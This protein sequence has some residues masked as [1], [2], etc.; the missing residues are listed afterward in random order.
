[1]S[2][3]DLYIDR[4]KTQC[5]VGGAISRAGPQVSKGKENWLRAEQRIR[6]QI[7]LPSLLSA[8]DCEC[9]E[10]ISFTPELPLSDGV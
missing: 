5:T 8:L 3:S 4:G 2:M 6:Q 7:W 9:D 10:P 1:M